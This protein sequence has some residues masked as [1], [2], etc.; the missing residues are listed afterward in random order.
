MFRLLSQARLDS[1]TANAIELSF[2]ASDGAMRYRL[3]AEKA[4]NPFT[5]AL[6]AG[7][8]LPRSLLA[9]MPVKP[10][11]ARALAQPARKK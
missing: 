2:A 7:F 8:T 4:N 5:H 1:A 11:A 6:F 9:D 3:T 10:K